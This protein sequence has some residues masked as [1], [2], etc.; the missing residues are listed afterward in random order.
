MCFFLLILV[1][2][3]QSLSIKV[4]FTQTASVT[5]LTWQLTYASA[6]SRLRCSFNVLLSVNLPLILLCIQ[7]TSGS[8]F[9]LSMPCCVTEHKQPFA[10]SLCQS[11]LGLDSPGQQTFYSLELLVGSTTMLLQVPI[12]GAHSVVQL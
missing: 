7:V 8:S 6:F 4:S 12:H 1:K 11:R 2:M 5:E 9:T 3:Q 10:T